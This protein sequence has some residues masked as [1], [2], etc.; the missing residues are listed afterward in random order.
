MIVVCKLVHKYI[1]DPPDLSTVSL[2]VDTVKFSEIIPDFYIVH[3]NRVSESRLLYRLQ[4][5]RKQLRKF[6]YMCYRETNNHCRSHGE[7]YKRLA[8]Y[9]AL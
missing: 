2:S 7:R 9:R 6:V 4:M 1:S 8:V 3:L 5:N